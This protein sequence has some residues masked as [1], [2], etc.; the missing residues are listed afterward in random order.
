MKKLPEAGEEAGAVG[1]D[2]AVLLAQTELHRE[3]VDGG[4]LLD[5]LVRGAEA[6]EADLLT[7]LGEPRV[8]KQ[9]G[10]T[11]ELMENVPETRILIQD[12]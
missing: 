1:P 11:D 4:E 3:P 2:L 9:R 5:F 7:E 10:V 6:G 8:S 12:I